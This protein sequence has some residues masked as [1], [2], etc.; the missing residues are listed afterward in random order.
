MTKVLIISYFYP[1]ANFVGGERTASWAKYLHEYDIYPI[2]VTRQWN[3]HQ[4]DLVDPIVNNEFKHE[5]YDTHEVYRLPYKR[6]LRDKCSDY[7][8]LKPIQKLLS[9]KELIFSN[10]K[11][12]SIPYKNLYYQAEKILSTENSISSVIISGR[13]FQAFHF[14]YLLKKKFQIKWI[15]DY[16]DEWTSHQSPSNQN[17]IW[18]FINKLERKSEIKWTSNADFFITV[19]ED[20]K[21]SISN[22]IGKP[23][24]V[25]MNGFDTEIRMLT[26]EKIN[27]E[28][29]EILYAG[30]LYPSQQ[31][32]LFINSISTVNSDRPGKL[33]VKFVGLNM[34]PSELQRVKALCCHLDFVEFIDR[35]PKDILK[36][37]I[38]QADVLLLTSFKDVK[39]WY[40][41]KLFEYYSSGKP[42]LLYP[43]DTGVMDDFISKTNSGIVFYKEKNC[44]NQLYL[45]IDLKSQ[46][47]SIEFKR[48]TTE[49]QFY[50]RK[51]QSRILANILNS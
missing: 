36:K 27:T 32:E 12:A 22:L 35:L 49:G 42:V 29:L 37:H 34:M 40:P 2:I 33:K 3:D 50:S 45:W 46:G 24:Q 17:F 5:K 16:R 28:Q 41:V 44:I 8:F 18:K 7:S 10:I 13:P 23:G 11:L 1:P 15:P 4:S 19:S 38:Q 31:I 48:N 25:V 51:N 30:S 14:G 6:T 47:K 39:G 9:L 20:W 26:P 21:N 43:G